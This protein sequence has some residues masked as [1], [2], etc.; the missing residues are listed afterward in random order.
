AISGVACSSFTHGG[1]LLVH[2]Y[3]VQGVWCAQF[4]D[5]QVEVGGRV[6]VGRQLWGSVQFL[7]RF[8]CA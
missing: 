8:V 3:L 1:Q 5:E 2:A 4:V 6:E 7:Q